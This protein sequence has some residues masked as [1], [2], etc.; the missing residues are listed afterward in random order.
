MEKIEHSFKNEYAVY[1]TQPRATVLKFIRRRGAAQPPKHTIVATSHTTLYVVLT[2]A[3]LAN[4]T[5]V[6][7]AE[8]RI[9]VATNFSRTAT[10]L[11]RHFESQTHH[12][13]QLAFGSTG[14]HY[15]QIMHGAPFDIFLAADA[16]RPALLEKN[17]AAV[18]GTRFTYA[19]G[20]LVLWS[21]DENRID[22]NADVLATGRFRK[23]AIAN[24]KLAPYGF[25]AREV[26]Q[27]R[28]LWKKLQ[29]R[30]V[31]GENIGQAYQFVRSGNAQLGFVAAA[32]VFATN[33]KP[34]GSYWEPD[35][36]MY[37]PIIQQAVIIKESSAA[38][39]FMAYIK[40]KTARAIMK[41]GGY[42]VTE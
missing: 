17:G 39:A 25:A 8:L 18:P 40:S 24:P 26:L 10:T 3:L 33:G 28:G 9:A 36:S 30:L 19:Q 12:T 31:R 20:R 15:A 13:I 4:S 7:A 34:A 23:L 16:R 2:I 1:Q 32:Q 38:R 41:E 22:T 27:A 11:A 29:P 35:P 14:K 37:T 5:L 42:L 21:P 6:Q